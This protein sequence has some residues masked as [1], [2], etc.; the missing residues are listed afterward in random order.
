MT[1]YPG[2]MHRSVALAL[3]SSSLVLA[4]CGS[5]T[6]AADAGSDAGPPLPGT[7]ENVS[8]ILTSSCAFA[9]CHGGAGA[10][11]S[12]LN[13]ATSLAAGTLVEDLSMPSCQYSAMPLLTP[14]EPSQS[15]LYLKVAGPHMGARVDFTPAASWDPGITPD[16]MGN[17]PAST[18]PLVERGDITFGA[19]M[20]QGSMGLDA[21]RAETIR[22]WIAAG[23]PGPTP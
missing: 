15:W 14:G 13:L 18:C 16:G 11:A 8:M 2:P 12:Q 23:A 21:S 7:Y 4:S 9:S 10:G 17:Y 1:M 3:A 19:M 5:P 22:L 6:P 20:P